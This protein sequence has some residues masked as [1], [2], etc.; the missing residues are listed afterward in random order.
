MIVVRN[1]TFWRNKMKTVEEIEIILAHQIG[2]EQYYKSQY[3]NFQYTDGVKAMWES[4]DSYWLL[5]LIGS[6][7]RTEPF[8]V[9]ELITFKDN[10]AVLTMKEDSNLPHKVS[11]KIRFTDF[12]LESIKLYLID[13][14]LLLP[15]EY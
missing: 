15:S 3:F 8:Q 6:Y 10:T 1:K 14:I 5:Q 12:P 11:K 4:C 7:R 9:W 13:G 2:T